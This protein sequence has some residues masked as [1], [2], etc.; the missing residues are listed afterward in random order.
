[1]L[2]VR[3][4][5]KYGFKHKRRGIELTAL[6]FSGSRTDKRQINDAFLPFLLVL[7][8]YSYSSCK[9]RLRGFLSLG[10]RQNKNLIPE[11]EY[12]LSCHACALLTISLLSGTVRTCQ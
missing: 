12:L 4:T 8:L 2:E 3:I 9:G 1:M 11:S 6:F 5:G 10:Y 7:A